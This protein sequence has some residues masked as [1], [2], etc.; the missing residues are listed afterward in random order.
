M[1]TKKSLV[2][3]KWMRVLLGIA[4]ATL[5]PA[6]LVTAALPVTN[7]WTDFELDSSGSIP[8]TAQ[9]GTWQPDTHTIVYSGL[10]G[11]KALSQWQN[12]GETNAFLK[13]NT[14]L[15]LAGTQVQ[16]DFDLHYGDGFAAFGLTTDA[17]ATSRPGQGTSAL[18]YLLFQ[19]ASGGYTLGVNSLKAGGDPTVTTSD[20]YQNLASQTAFHNSDNPF[21]G[22]QYWDHIEFG[23]V[24]G[25][26]TGTLK[27][28]GSTISTTVGLVNPGGIV[29]GVFFIGAKPASLDYQVD[30]V[31][32]TY[33]V[34]PEPT[35]LALT[36][37]GIVGLIIARRR[38][39]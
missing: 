39:T 9:V 7:V 19:D 10:G 11:S 22:G 5:V 8:T 29:D 13:G 30:N 14:P 33:A 4:V 3:S 12:G 34:I 24:I 26:S 25:D 36:G 16:L 38:R 23:Y 1:N 28:N 32:V 35:T 27:I 2:R 18:V 37:L 20:N 31:L 17:S 21:T 6:G 15:T